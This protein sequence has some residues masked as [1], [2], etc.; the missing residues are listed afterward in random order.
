MYNICRHAT[1]QETCAPLGNGA[2]P[3]AAPDGK[4]NDYEC[5][6]DDCD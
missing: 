5:Y 2:L 4:C 3:V 1:F 6:R